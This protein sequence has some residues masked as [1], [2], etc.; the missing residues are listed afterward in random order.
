MVLG[1]ALGALGSPGVTSHVTTLPGA[2]VPPEIQR[3]PRVSLHLEEAREHTCTSERASLPRRATVG[4]A[5]RGEETGPPCGWR[6]RGPALQAEGGSASRLA[7]CVASV[8]SKDSLLC[9]RLYTG[10]DRRLHMGL[11][12]VSH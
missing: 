4:R 2:L 10:G 9:S 11:C 5:A 6:R 1:G 12:Y 8:G 7:G 3:C